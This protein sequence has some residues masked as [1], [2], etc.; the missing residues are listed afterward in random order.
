MPTPPRSRHLDRG[1]GEPGRSHVLDRDDRVGLHQFEARLDQQ[2]FG[3]RVA[4]LHR[5]PLRLGI[6][7]E[8]GGGHR[9][10]VNAVAA[11]LGADI[12]HGVAHSGGGTEKNAVGAGDADGHRIDQRVAVVGGMKI[13]L[14]ADGRHAHAIAVAADAAHHAIDDA[15]RGGMVRAAEAQRV[16]VGDRPRAHRE[17]V[18]Q[19]AADAG[20]RTLVRLD[21]ARVVVAL[22]L[23]DG[24][25]ALAD[26]DDAGVLAGAVDHPGRARRQLAQPDAGGFVGAVLRPH[27][28]EHAELGQRRRAAQD[29]EHARVLVP[30]EPELAGERLVD[31]GFG[32]APASTGGAAPPQA[33][34]AANHGRR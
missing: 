28:A 20:R 24:R 23:E 16:Q 15:P 27:D 34:Q 11:G 3:E 33:G 26:G 13:D 5:R 22:H 6:G 25:Q 4:D 7:A 18:A 31:R 1:G 12:D 14:A 10:A 21:E 19:D 30:A 29:R 17:H 32:H 2:L 8:R 9:G